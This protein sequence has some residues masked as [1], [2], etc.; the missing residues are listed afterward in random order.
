[1]RPDAAPPPLRALL[2][3]DAR[4]PELAIVGALAVNLYGLAAFTAWS[5]GAAATSYGALVLAAIGAA[6]AIWA[7]ARWVLE[8]SWPA[9]LSRAA[10]WTPEA[11]RDRALAALSAAPFVQSVAGVLVENV[12]A[13]S[14]LRA[15]SAELGAFADDAAARRLELEALDA[16]MAALQ[17]ELDPATPAVHRAALRERV[18]SEAA[19]EARARR[20]RAAVDDRHALLERGLVALR[21][22]A[23]LEALRDRGR[24]LLGQ[25]EARVQAADAL[26][27]TFEMDL[28]PLADDLDAVRALASDEARTAAVRG[29]VSA[30]TTQR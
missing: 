22:Q 20:L 23:E 26:A 25:R 16:R 10:P 21:R 18:A 13:L 24:A 8:P 30:L 29:E 17:A 12:P 1:M 15:W 2:R 9:L 27:T 19:L 5:H 28:A 3:A 14:R 6:W 11:A 7:L 4:A